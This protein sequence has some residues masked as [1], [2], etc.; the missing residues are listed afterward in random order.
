MDA[1]PLPGVKGQHERKFC[2]FQPKQLTDWGNNYCFDTNDLP[3]IDPFRKDPR[4][5]RFLKYVGATAYS[6]VAMWVFG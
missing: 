2:D 1:Y 6:L 4:W 3:L 5:L